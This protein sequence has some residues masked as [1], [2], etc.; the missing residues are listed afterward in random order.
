MKKYSLSIFISLFA[1]FAGR[2]QDM[3]FSLTQAVE[4][5]IKNS[6][7]YLNAELDLQNAVYRKDETRGLGLPQIN[8]SIDVKDYLSIPTSLIPGDFVGQPGTYI[9]VKFG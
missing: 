2:A 9:P 8:G 5:A 4:Y 6:P 7:S 1:V 3:K